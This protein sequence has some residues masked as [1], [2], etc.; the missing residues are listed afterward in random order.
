MPAWPTGAPGGR[1]RRLALF[2]G[3]P[4]RKVSSGALCPR[5]HNALLLPICLGSPTTGQ[6]AVG[7]G[8]LPHA[9]VHA[10][11]GGVRHPRRLDRADVLR[12]GRDVLADAGQRRGRQ[13]VQG[14]QIRQECALIHAGQRARL[15]A[16]LAGTGDDFVV[17]VSQPHHERDWQAQDLGEDPMHE[18]LGH[19]GACVP[20][21]SLVVHCRAACVPQQRLPLASWQRLHGSGLRVEHGKRPHQAHSTVLK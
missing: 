9:K 6:L 8:K 16:N 1:P 17:H 15:H 5:A 13:H 3:L 20:H 19:V 18:V 10:G 2:A 12:D 21:V 11:G 7:A 4:Q 14:R